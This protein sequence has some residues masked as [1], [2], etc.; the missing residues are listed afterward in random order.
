MKARP[1]TI[2]TDSIPA[3]GKLYLGLG[4]TASYA[5]ADA[6]DIPTI[7]KGRNKRAVIP[8]LRQ[9]LGLPPLPEPP[10]AA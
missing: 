5:A 4:A 10:E 8:L 7:G 9:K 1:K 3:A 2:A 6:G